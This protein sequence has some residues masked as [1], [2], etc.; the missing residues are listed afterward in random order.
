[1]KTELKVR[2]NASTRRVELQVL[3]DGREQAT[4]SLIDAKAD[5]LAIQLRE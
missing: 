1:M 5:S 2:V 4:I 3:S